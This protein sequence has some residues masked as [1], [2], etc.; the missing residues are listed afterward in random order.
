[1]LSS[2]GL[3]THNRPASIGWIRYPTLSLSNLALYQRATVTQFSLSRY[4]CVKINGS[5]QDTPTSRWCF[6]NRK[7]PKVR[8]YSP[9][10]G[11]TP[12]G[13][14]RCYIIV[15]RM[16]AIWSRTLLIFKV[17]YI[18]LKR[19]HHNF[20]EEC[21]LLTRSMD[22]FLFEFQ[23]KLFLGIPICR[24]LRAILMGSSGKLL[25][26]KQNYNNTEW[27]KVIA[28]LIMLIRLRHMTSYPHN[29]RF[30]DVNGLW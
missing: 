29:I 16:S 25:Y 14:P 30:N 19:K 28:A 22:S 6:L 3:Y 23:R 27:G 15:L 13:P 24:P 17:S 21:D 5:F 26:N 12:L 11:P 9:S 20:V 1:M 8:L 7:Q 10:L 18:L 2:F 4:H